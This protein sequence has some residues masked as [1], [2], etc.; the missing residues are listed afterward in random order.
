VISGPTAPRLPTQPP[1]PVL[2]TRDAT[3]SWPPRTKSSR[4]RGLA[5]PAGDSAFSIPLRGSHPDWAS[6]RAYHG[7]G[8]HHHSRAHSQY[9]YHPNDRSS[10]HTNRDEAGC[11]INTSTRYRRGPSSSYIQ[12]SGSRHGG[13]CQF[14][15]SLRVYNISVWWRVDFEGSWSLS[16][17][18]PDVVAEAGGHLMNIM[19]IT[20]ASK[21]LERYQH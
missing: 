9:P 8:F 16:C 19:T 11:N 17:V 10:N 18:R 5:M 20:A 21:I 2:S 12:R 6:R 13:G 14:S 4:G 1:S 15:T 7:P 3:L